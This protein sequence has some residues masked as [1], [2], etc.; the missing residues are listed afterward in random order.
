MADWLQDF[1][2]RHTAGQGSRDAALKHLLQQAGGMRLFGT[3]GADV[4][5]RPDGSTV[6]LIEGSG[7]E[8]DHWHDDTADERIAA[9]VIALDR[10]P[11][12]ASL[13]PSRPNDAQDCAG[14]QGSGRIHAIVCAK[15]NGL[16]WAS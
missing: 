8:S 13:L 10:Y 4:F 9:L 2:A 3:M 15:C 5:L 11:E 14:C 1:V 7:T 12:L 6:S 16:G